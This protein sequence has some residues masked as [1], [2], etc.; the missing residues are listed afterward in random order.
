MRIQI[1]AVSRLR[2]GPEKDLF[3][4]YVARFDKIGRALSLGPIELIE[5]E[6][7][8]GGRADVEG[9][10]LLKAVRENAHICALDERGT[11]RSSPDLAT[12]MARLRD[13]GTS[14]LSFVIGGA[15]GLSKDVRQAAQ[16]AL[17][18]GKMVWPHALARVMLAEEIYRAGTILAGSP[19]HRA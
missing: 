5:V 16:E 12:H 9:E 2:R 18:F 13:D 3:D 10:R 8:S 19:Y 1:C 17:S 4:D 7:R 6:D 14:T 11:L 15:D